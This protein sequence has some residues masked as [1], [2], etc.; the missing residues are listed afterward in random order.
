MKI[1]LRPALNSEFDYCE[2]VYFAEMQSILD[3]L[4][5]VLI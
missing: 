4:G 5:S 1:D 2:Q 3:E